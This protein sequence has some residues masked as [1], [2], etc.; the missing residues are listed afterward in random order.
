MNFTFLGGAS[1]R[2]YVTTLDTQPST[3]LHCNPSFVRLA[4][5]TD[6]EQSEPR[7]QIVLDGKDDQKRERMLM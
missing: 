7:Y 2:G 4:F 6:A 3:E 1:L 5:P